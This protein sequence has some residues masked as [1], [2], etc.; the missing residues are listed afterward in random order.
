M[1]RYY[2][3]LAV[4]TLLLTGLVGANRLAVVGADTAN[5]PSLVISQLKI[6]SSN[7]QFVTLYNSSSAN[8]DMTKYQLEYFNSYDLSK[9]TSSKLISLTGTLPPHSYFMVNDSA[10]QLC[11]QVTVDSVSLGFSSTAGMVEVVALTQASPGSSAATSLQDYVGWSKTTAS[12]AQTLP[13]N[14]A[15][16]LDRQPLDSQSNPAITVP[17]GGTWLAV[18]PD[19]TNSCNLVSASSP[20]VSVPT[21]LSQLLPGAEPPATIVAST[22]TAIDSTATL[23]ASDIGLMAPRIS[24]L[25]PNPNG[26]GNDGTDEYIELYN[27]NV[28]AFDLSG[29]RLQTGTT[30]LHT[31][32]FPFGTTLTPGGFIAFYSSFTGLSLSNSGGQASLLDPFGNSIAT[33]SVYGTAKDGQA[34]ALANASWAW[35]THP[36]P[37]QAN[38][39]EA[40][41]TKQAAKTTSSST[42][43][44]AKSTPKATTSKTVNAATTAQHAADTGA[45]LSPIHP[46]VLALVAG[47]ALLYGAYEYRSD[48]ANHLL[49]FRRY[50]RTR[51]ARRLQTARR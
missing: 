33:T 46:W 22:Q 38:I 9:A 30:S 11:Y 24:E 12:G 1:R 44:K 51:R 31:F 2:Q 26:T 48:L 17:G 37:G 49:K 50:I 36:T 21:G 15:A 32:T 41:A 29:F 20:T 43:S 39:I 14:T 16:F 23:P 28:A 42:K 47:L 34:W 10:L 40:P 7:G 45:D 25:L 6:T 3:Q 13:T 5:V 19:T 35:T 4:V 27:P 8:L 18:Q